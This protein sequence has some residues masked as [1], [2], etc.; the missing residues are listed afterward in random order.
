MKN[1][2]L[3]IILSSLI[4]TGCVGYYPLPVGDQSVQDIQVKVNGSW[5]IVKVH[6]HTPLTRKDSTNWTQNGILL[7]RLQIIPGIKDGEAMFVQ[8]KGAALPKFD[9]T[10]LP[11][12]I[13]E[14]TESSI[15]KML[16]EGDA[17]VKTSKLRPHR[18]GKQHG[19]LFNLEAAV[20]EG[21]NYKGL[22]GAILHQERLYMIFF[23]AATPYYF[24]KILPEA[25]SI[26]KSATITSG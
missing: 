17:V 25:E 9:S 12:E 18:F 6:T 3:G 1:V 16:G 11:N 14:F 22:V 23:V 2:V 13:E 7:D 19:I 15:S 10:M 5:N 20:S 24:D 26:I 8:T 4:L 21:P